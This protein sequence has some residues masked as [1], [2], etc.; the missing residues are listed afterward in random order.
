MKIYIPE[1]YSEKENRLKGGEEE[2]NIITVILGAPIEGKILIFHC[3]I[4]GSPL[5]K[6]IGKIVSVIQGEVPSE[7]PLIVKCLKSNCKQN[8][9]IEKIL[10][11]RKTFV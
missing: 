6:Y 9:L 1:Y 11:R 3:H 8:Y 4:C 7:L 10:S 2:I 5:F